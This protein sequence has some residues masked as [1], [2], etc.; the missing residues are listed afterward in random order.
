MIRG[1]R[2][3]VPP[4]LWL[5]ACLLAAGACLGETP[6]G[7]APGLRLVG[8]DATA[9]G[10][11]PVLHTDIDVGVSGTIARVRVAQ[12]F[13]NPG[14]DWAEGVYVFPLPDKAAVDR[15]TLAYA[16]RLVEGEIRPRAEARRQYERARKQGRGASLVEQQ[17]GNVFTTRVANIPPATTVDVTIEYQE[18][19]AW[20]DDSFTLRLPLVVAPRYLPG[21]PLPANTHDATTGW[22]TATDQVP[23]APQISPPVVAGGAGVNPVSLHIDLHAG[24]DLAEITS[25]HHPVTVQPDGYGRYRVGLRE[26]SVPANRDF[27]LR[28]RP[29]SGEMPGAALFTQAWEGAQHHLLTVMPA[30]AAAGGER[31][32]LP[33]ELI[34]VVDSSGSMHGESIAQARAALQVAL[35]GLRPVDRFNLVRFDSGVEALFDTARP[36]TVANLRQ[37]RDFVARLQASG[38]T[39]MAPA[40]ALALR[41]DGAASLRQVVFVTDGA[42]GN[43][44]AL[45][46]LIEDR[47]GRSRLFTVGIGAAPNALFMRQAAR[48]GRGTA[49]FI[50]DTAEVADQIV[51]LLRQLSRPQLTDVQLRW[52]DAAGE[53][54]AA[55]E[56]T[57]APARLPDLYAGEPLVVAA[58]TR[59]PLAAALISGRLGDRAWH[60]RVELTGGARASGV[61]ALWARAVIDELRADIVRGGDPARVREAVLELAL[62]HR[63]VTA[64]TSLVAVDRRPLRPADADFRQHALPVALPAGWS[65]EAVFGRL[66]ATATPAPGLALAGLALLIL[67]WSLWPRRCPPR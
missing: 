61:H 4:G 12:R 29:R 26:A 5:L 65:T 62:R 39:E 25:L 60:T 67:G 14:P 66:P 22:A 47:L 35:R 64:Y 57:Q 37:A 55:S 18:S 20:H 33:R 17:R 28:W 48:F 53:A 52:L 32:A 7:Q 27:V 63:L 31:Q 50:G 3:T 24:L 23:D 8:A 44:Q 38:G 58:R 13:R 40:L 9:L 34:L 10:H 30:Q 49:T 2:P 54:L 6:G 36:A 46:E 16:G 15:L 59:R 42:V 56:V 1:P 21:S 45:F 43:E 51:G 11:A 41:D 19:L